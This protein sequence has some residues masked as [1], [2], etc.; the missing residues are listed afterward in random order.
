M[1]SETPKHA[2][3]LSC[4]VPSLRDSVVLVL[5]NCHFTFYN[6]LSTFKNAH[7]FSTDICLP[8]F[9]IITKLGICVLL[10]FKLNN[11]NY[12]IAFKML[13]K[14]WSRNVFHNINIECIQLEQPAVDDICDSLN[15]H[16]MH[17][18]SV[19]YCLIL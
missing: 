12:F 5:H 7:W 8:S 9:N 2:L 17:Y 10:S 14:R 16:L 18:N 19:K 11:N 3:W 6:I 13:N 1:F 4:F 15:G